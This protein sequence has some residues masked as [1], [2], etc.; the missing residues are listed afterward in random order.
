MYNKGDDSATLAIREGKGPGYST[1]VVRGNSRP[2]IGTRVLGLRR[3]RTNYVPP[4][5]CLGHGARER[6]RWR[7]CEGRC[8][9]SAYCSWVEMQVEVCGAKSR[10]VIRQW[11]IGIDWIFWSSRCIDF[12]V[13]LVKHAVH[14][15]L[16]CLLG[17]MIVV[18]E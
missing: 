15:P 2:T 4:L 14:L 10:E 7:A 3:S 9:S 13:V 12:T 1:D 18:V 16:S 17:Y 8:L 11:L 6:I 5:E